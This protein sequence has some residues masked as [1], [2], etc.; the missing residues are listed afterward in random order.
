MHM[1]MR[2]VL[3]TAALLATTAAFA[4]APQQPSQQDNLQR[5]GA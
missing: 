3:S 2:W 4:Q 1:R 5:L